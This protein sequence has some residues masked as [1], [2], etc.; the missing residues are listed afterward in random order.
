MSDCSQPSFASHIL[1][2][3]LS[4]Q[5]DVS[6]GAEVNPGIS[7]PNLPGPSSSPGI[8]E[9]VPQPSP[10]GGAQLRTPSWGSLLGCLQ[11]IPTPALGGGV[12]TRDSV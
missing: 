1:L 5:G 4:S 12:G 3:L 2:L 10:C 9:R 11:S 8:G 6:W 7:Y